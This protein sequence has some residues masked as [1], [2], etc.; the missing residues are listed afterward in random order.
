MADRKLEDHP[1]DLRTLRDMGAPHALVEERRLRGGG[2]PR[3]S[4]SPGDLQSA[5]CL[6]KLA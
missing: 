3:S 5:A 6:P 2:E 1:E 4:S